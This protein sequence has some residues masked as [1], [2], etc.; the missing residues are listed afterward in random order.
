MISLGPLSWLIQMIDKLCNILYLSFFLN[1]CTR[2]K[3]I[4]KKV[5]RESQRDKGET[6][7]F[8][9]C[10]NSGE[11]DVERGFFCATFL[12]CYCKKNYFLL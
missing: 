12:K 10:I 1:A 3:K 11:I 6:Q 2:R 8:F 7:W 4:V 5:S 9:V